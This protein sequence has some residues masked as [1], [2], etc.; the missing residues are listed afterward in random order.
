MLHSSFT[1]G[2]RYMQEN[3]QDAVAICRVHGPLDLFVAFTCNPKRLE[4]DEALLFEP[5]QTL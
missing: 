4:I 1:G 2:R 3:Y 5:G